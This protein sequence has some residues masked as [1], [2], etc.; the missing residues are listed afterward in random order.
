MFFTFGR[1]K[2]LK[3]VIRA[4]LFSS[5]DSLT[6]H[7]QLH[8]Q[9]LDGSSS[10]SINRASQADVGGAITTSQPAGMLGACADT[11]GGD[12]SGLPRVWQNNTSLR[13]PWCLVPPHAAPDNRHA[14]YLNE[15][16]GIECMPGATLLGPLCVET[17]SV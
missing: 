5:I 2:V 1:R 7:G 4:W 8:L 16:I 3:A 17:E 6:R 15:L 14:P 12:G 13:R 11:P 9:T 10:S